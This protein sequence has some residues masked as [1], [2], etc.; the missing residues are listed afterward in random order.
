MTIRPTPEKEAEQIPFCSAV[1]YTSAACYLASSLSGVV[2]GGRDKLE[3]RP[4]ISRTSSVR[5]W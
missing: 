5:M 4:R 2:Y 1:F 3:R